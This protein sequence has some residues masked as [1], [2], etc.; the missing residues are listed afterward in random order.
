MNDPGDCTNLDIMHPELLTQEQIVAVLTKRQIKLESE[1]KAVLLELF[2]AHILPQPQRQYRENR[3]G[4]KNINKRKS[5]QADENEFSVKKAK[6]SS[7]ESPRLF[8]PFTPESQKCI[9]PSQINKDRKVIQLS[10]PGKSSKRQKMG[11]IE[12]SKVRMFSGWQ[13]V[14]SHESSV[15]KCKMNFGI[16]LPQT[17]ETKKVPVI[18]WLSGLTCTEQNFV[19]KAGAQ[20]YANEEGIA[21]VAP[22]T[23]PRGCNIE[24]EEESWDFGTGAGFYVD[25]TEEKWRNN[26]RM[27]S[28][29]TEELPKIIG[30]NF[31][32]DTSN[33]SI[34]GHSMGGH[35]ALTIFFKNADK[36]KSVS[37][38][39]PICNPIECP[40]GQKAFNGYLGQNK[41][42]WKNYDACEMAKNFNGSLKIPILVDQGKADSFLLQK[43]LLPEN[44][45][46]VCSDKNLPVT[47]R[48][49]NEY[50]HS[51]FFIATFIEDH[52]KHHSQVLNGKL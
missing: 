9:P 38:F 42:T 2:K 17:S 45:E 50:D 1:D 33:A 5:Q 46:K 13:K 30:G 41:E 31:P 12:V 34:M 52:I 10:S 36:F 6:L 27:Y 7:K 3:R 16:Y 28:Y 40:W 49:Q 18:Y 47:I 19:T 20:K 4:K 48:M 23:S 15:L 32:V 11:L 35:G 14:F 43:Q 44:L 22:D 37:A 26:Y 25:A 39:A 29:I 8:V 51:Y 21:I 24:G